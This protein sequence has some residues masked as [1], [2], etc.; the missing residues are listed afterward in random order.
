MLYCCFHIQHS[1]THKY[2]SLLFC[3][4]SALSLE[5]MEFLSMGSQLTVKDNYSITE[6]RILEMSECIH[7]GFYSDVLGQKRSL[8]GLELYNETCCQTL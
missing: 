8:M 2:A 1:S 7:E 6:Y 5:I 4:F 3:I